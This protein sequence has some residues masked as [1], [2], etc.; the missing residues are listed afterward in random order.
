MLKQNIRDT[1]Q[2]DLLAGLDVDNLHDSQKHT[3][4]ILNNNIP[5]FKILNV[6]LNIHYHYHSVI[7]LMNSRKNTDKPASSTKAIRQ[8]QTSLLLRQKQSYPTNTDKPAS[9][10]KAIRQIQTSLLLRQ[11]LSGKYRQAC[12]F[13]KSYPANSTEK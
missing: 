6:H 7:T 3:Q 4:S 8:I 13:D 2:I 1:F 10:T 9:S 12:F 11:K 5:T